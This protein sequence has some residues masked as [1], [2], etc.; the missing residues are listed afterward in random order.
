[1]NKYFASKTDDKRTMEVH[2]K[3]G[4]EFWAV[5]VM[6]C[7]MPPE[8]YQTLRHGFSTLRAL[9]AYCGISGIA[10][11]PTYSHY[12]TRMVNKLTS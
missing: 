1:M 2:S 4:M 6:D 10:L 7:P 5:F 9:R 3:N 12:Q 11:A 8:H